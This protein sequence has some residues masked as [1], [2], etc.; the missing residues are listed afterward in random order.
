MAFSRYD[1]QCIY[2]HDSNFLCISSADR[3]GLSAYKGSLGEENECKRIVLLF[4]LLS[5]FGEFLVELGLVRCPG[6]C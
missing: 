2:T 5:E 6:A 3:S 4:G 1:A